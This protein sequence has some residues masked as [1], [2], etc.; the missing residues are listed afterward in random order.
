MREEGGWLNFSVFVNNSNTVVLQVRTG[1][2]VNCFIK[3][4]AVIV[5]LD[6]WKSWKRVVEGV[7]V[8]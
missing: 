8:S 6:N 3:V 1:D 4:A 2:D 5:I 7:G